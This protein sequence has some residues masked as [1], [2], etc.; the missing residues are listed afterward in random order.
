M[1][2]EKLKEEAEKLLSWKAKQCQR[3]VNKLNEQSL[4]IQY[5]PELNS[6]ESHFVCRFQSEN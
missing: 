1:K 2:R 4:I 5:Q 3:S 6:T